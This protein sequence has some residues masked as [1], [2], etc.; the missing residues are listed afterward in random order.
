[1]GKDGRKD[2]MGT[3]NVNDNKVNNNRSCPCLTIFQAIVDVPSE[4]Y[5]MSRKQV[6]PMKNNEME[7][8]YQ[9]I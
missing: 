4:S 7:Q 1:M 3:K 6:Y 2:D 9:I 5:S 8:N